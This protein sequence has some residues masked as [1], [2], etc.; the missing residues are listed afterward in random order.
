MK[1]PLYVL[2]P[3]SEEINIWRFTIVFFSKLTYSLKICI[4]KSISDCNAK[5]KFSY[6]IYTSMFQK[7]ICLVKKIHILSD[8]DF[9]GSYCYF[10]GSESNLA[11]TLDTKLHSKKTWKS[12]L[13]MPFTSLIETALSILKDM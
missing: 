5:I 12:M 13:D 7:I 3:H 2:K 11:T 1:K 10:G 9:S 8:E 4:L 6:E